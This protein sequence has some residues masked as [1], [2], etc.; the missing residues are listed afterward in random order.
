MAKIGRERILVGAMFLGI[1]LGAIGRADRMAKSH[2]E[3]SRSETINYVLKNKRGYLIDYNA[4]TKALNTSS[5]IMDEKGEIIVWFDQTDKIMRAALDQYSNLRE[6]E[7]RI[8]E[9]VEEVRQTIK[10]SQYPESLNP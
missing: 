7:F 4:T 9:V 10:V 6:A 5:T 8:Y 1:G 2:K 3:E